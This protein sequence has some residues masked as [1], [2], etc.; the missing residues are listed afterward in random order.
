[1]TDSSNVRPI[2]PDDPRVVALGLGNNLGSILPI[3]AAQQRIMELQADRISRL[4][5][6]V[7]IVA[8]GVAESHNLI[9]QLREAVVET[10]QKGGGN[11]S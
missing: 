9:A 3:L 5:E 7:H 4:L 6:E 1:M 11:E 2:K 8:G 10:L